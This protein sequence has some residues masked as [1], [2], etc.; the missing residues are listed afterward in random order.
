MESSSDI[1]DHQTWERC[2]EYICN[3]AEV[4]LVSPSFLA[5]ISQANLLLLLQRYLT[6]Y[7]Y[8]WPSQYHSLFVC[9]HVISV[10][11]LLTVVARM[12]LE[13][14]IVMT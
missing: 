1:T 4:L 6:L 2:A 5:D 10:A 7:I 8:Y 13:R 12:I 11:V 9:N 3:H 14:F